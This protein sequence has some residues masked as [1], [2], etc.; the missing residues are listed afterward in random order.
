MQAGP[1]P[2]A[3]PNAGMSGSDIFARL[4]GGGMGGGGSGGMGGGG[5]GGGFGP[6]GMGG[7]AI[8]QGSVE[9][10]LRAMGGRV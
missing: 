10:L 3:D 8:N 6:T 1:S 2:G 5:G 9:A 7:G 4:F